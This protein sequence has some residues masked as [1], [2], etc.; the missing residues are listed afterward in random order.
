MNGDREGSRGGR[1][2]SASRATSARALVAGLVLSVPAAG[3]QPAMPRPGDVVLLG[4]VFHHM[5]AGIRA[6]EHFGLVLGRRK[7]RRL[8]LRVP[9]ELADPAT[10]YELVLTVRR[11]GSKADVD[12]TLQPFRGPGPWKGELE[13]GRGALVETPLGGRGRT[14]R[15]LV[16]EWGRAAT[17]PADKLA[18]H[19]APRAPSPA[20]EGRP[21]ERPVPRAPV[22]DAESPAPPVTARRPA[23]AAAGGRLTLD[24]R[25]VRGE[26]TLFAPRVRLASGEAFEVRGGG[27]LSV[28]G[29]PPHEGIVITGRAV[30]SGAACLL[31][32]SVQTGRQV[33]AEGAAVH[34]VDRHR[35]ALRVSVGEPLRVPL[36]GEL[37]A[38]GVLPLELVVRCA[39]R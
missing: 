21:A 4:R 32:L 23:P 9:V 24:L 28:G 25:V 16:L 36:F 13:V 19:L 29:G 26:A 38:T 11:R 35:R 15:H 34:L 30:R 6:V 17:F 1:R 33:G 10:G 37:E 2:S 14:E 7:A 5:P 31:D 18:R 8:V 3:A 12:W 22:G 39:L 20:R 27:R